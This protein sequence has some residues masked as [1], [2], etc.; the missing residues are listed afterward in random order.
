MW[1]FYG[2]KP[3]FSQSKITSVFVR[4]T[5]CLDV[6]GHNCNKP[7]NHPSRPAVP[8]WVD[9]SPEADLAK[10]QKN[11]FEE[12]FANFVGLRMTH[13]HFCMLDI[14][15]TIRNSSLYCSIQVFIRTEQ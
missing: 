5:S 2:A 13:L 6:C 4:N 14:V 12:T 8:Q 15:R 3:L 7:A 10:F 1:Q 9:L 11:F